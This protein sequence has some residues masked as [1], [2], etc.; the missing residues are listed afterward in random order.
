[1]DFRTGGRNDALRVDVILHGESQALAVWIRRPVVNESTIA[2]E[3]TETRHERAA[4][5]QKERGQGNWQP[6]RISK[7]GVSHAR[8]AG[9]L[10]VVCK[11][12]VCR[13]GYEARSLT[14]RYR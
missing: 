8:N 3:L 2:G 13:I 10:R 1:K 4:A 5:A 11:Q 12:D 6:F 7:A 14:E 9:C